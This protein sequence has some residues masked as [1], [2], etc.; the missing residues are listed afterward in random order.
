M[1]QAM[2]S[3]GWRVCLTTS[4][5]APKTT[6]ITRYKPGERPWGRRETSWLLL[7]KRGAQITGGRVVITVKVGA[8]LGARGPSDAGRDNSGR[9]ASLEGT[10]R[11]H[12]SVD[13]PAGQGAEE[14]GLQHSWAL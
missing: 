4:V 13:L 10:E 7:Q 1:T 6:S 5:A 9:G 11:G 14:S 2:C 12:Q 3:V 8:V